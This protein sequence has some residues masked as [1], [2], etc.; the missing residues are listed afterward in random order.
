MKKPRGAIYSLTIH[1]FTAFFERSGQATL[2]LNLSTLMNLSCFSSRRRAPRIYDP[3]SIVYFVHFFSARFGVSDIFPISELPYA[4]F[5]FCFSYHFFFRLQF[6]Y[7]YNTLYV[8]A[9]IR[10]S[11]YYIK[12]L[13]DKM[14]NISVLVSEYRF[15]QLTKLLAFPSLEPYAKF[16]NGIWSLV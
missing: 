13:S 3:F 16:E 11:V 6:T 2:S 9:L 1:F 7:Q 14:H 12:R 4:K 5:Q 8:Y 10:V 15:G